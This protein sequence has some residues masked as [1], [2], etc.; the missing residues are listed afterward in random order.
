MMRAAAEAR[1][2]HVLDDAQHAQAHLRVRN[3]A[4]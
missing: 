3:A 1:T 2:A 4:A